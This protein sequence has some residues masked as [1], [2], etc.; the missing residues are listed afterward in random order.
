M[1]WLLPLLLVL[2]L[3][4]LPVGVSAWR[5]GAV[6]H[7]SAA[8][9]DSTG[10]APDP[11]TATEAVVQVYCAASWG[12]K[13]AVADHCWIAMKPENATGYTRYDV[14]AW[15]VRGGGEAIRVNL[16]GVPDGNWAGNRPRLLLDR[17]GAAAA[18]LIP[19]IEQAVTD[20]P[21]RHTYRTWPGPNSNTFIAWIAREVPGLGLDL[22]PRAIGKDF[23]GAR[24]LAPAPSHTGFQLSLG[25]VLGLIVARVEG[26]ELNLSGVVLGIDP[27]DLAITLPGLGRL[28]ILGD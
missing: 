4:I 28:S 12:L 11:V 26:L 15:G 14:V 10:M 19:Q 25:G 18:A 1:R 23:L 21:Y 17:R 6:A 22:P 8:R 5:Q 13:G 9:W 7:W 20:Y 3:V 24:I 16:R 27:L 2:T